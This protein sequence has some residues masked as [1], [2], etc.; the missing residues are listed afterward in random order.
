MINRMFVICIAAAL[1]P[2]MLSVEAS[3]KGFGGHSHHHGFGH[4]LY[5]GTVADYAL[6]DETVGV[7]STLR[8]LGPVAPQSVALSCHHSLE[9]KTVPSE[10][11]GTRAITITR[12]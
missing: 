11:G 3:A 8:S 7:V 6:G 4:W 1:G 12:C 5:G 2:A 9:I 10:D